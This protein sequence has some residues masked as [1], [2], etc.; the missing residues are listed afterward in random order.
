MMEL[1]EKIKE[2][3]MRKIFG[4]KEIGIIQKQLFGIGL[5]PSEQTILSREIRK[6]FIAIEL[7]CPHK[8]DFSLKKGVLPKELVEKTKKKILNSVYAKNIKRIIWFGSFVRGEATFNS[9]VDLCVEFD[10]IDLKDSIKFETFVSDEMLDVKIYN[11]LPIKLKK[12]VDDGKIIF[13]R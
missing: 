2:P 6:K 8:K 4:K 10:E 13:R 9:D 5:T 1:F 3:I 11:F 12:E 7:L